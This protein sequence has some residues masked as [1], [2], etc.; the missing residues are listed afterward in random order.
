MFL[1]KRMDRFDQ[2]TL[3]GQ[4]L[5]RELL[6][7]MQPLLEPSSTDNELTDQIQQSLQPITAD[8]DDFSIFSGFTIR[9][10]TFRRFGRFDFF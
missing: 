1:L 9:S 8:A 6:Q 5:L 7:H 10:F 3:V 2:S 4:Y